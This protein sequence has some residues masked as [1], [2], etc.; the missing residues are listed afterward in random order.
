MS[1]NT[2]NADLDV[3]SDLGG[4]YLKKFDIRD[5]GPQRFA[6]VGTDRI[7]FEA[8]NGRPAQTRI[9]LTFG[10]EPTRKMSLNKTNLRVLV[11]VWGPKPA[12]WVGKVVQVYF[13][14]EVMFGAEKTGG[15][16]VRA[17]VPRL[18]APKP[19]PAPAVDPDDD[20]VF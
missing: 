11:K 7:T 1:T 8:K 10:G 19:A 3:S 12:A 5:S 20:I 18:V 13:D 16:R 17:G 4:E 14:P 15:L 6:I 2:P 9:V